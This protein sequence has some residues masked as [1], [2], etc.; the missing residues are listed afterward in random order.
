[1]FCSL[2]NDGFCLDGNASFDW[3]VMPVLTGWLCFYGFNWMVL[4]YS[5]WNAGLTE[6]TLEILSGLLT[7]FPTVRFV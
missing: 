3:M 7:E 6:A 5:L 2:W 4:F 1:M